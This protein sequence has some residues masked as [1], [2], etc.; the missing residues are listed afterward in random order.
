VKGRLGLFAFLLAGPAF[1][2]DAGP[3]DAKGPSLDA[4]ASITGCT[5]QIPGGKRRPDL[6]E[7]FPAKGQSGHIAVLEVSLLHGKG[8]SVLPSGF[9]LQ[10]TDAAM[11]TLEGARF[12]LPDADGG[13]GPAKE[14]ETQGEQQ[15]TR[16]KIPFVPLPDKPGRHDLSLPPVP[17]TIQRA[18]G[19]LVTLCTKSHPIVVEDPTLSTPEPKPKHNPEPRRQLEVWTV[20]K[21]VAIAAL[22]ALVVGALLAWL[23]GKWLRRP[24]P[25][26]PPPPPRPPWEVAIEE[27]F[28]IRHAGLIKQQRFAVHFDRVS[29]AI[30]KYLGER[31]GFDGL[32]CTTR[33]TLLLLNEVRP[34]IV[35]LDTIRAFLR[36]ADLVKFARLTPTEEECE[37]ALERAERIVRQTIPL[38]GQ[39]EQLAAP[40]VEAEPH[41]SE[42]SK[43]APRTPIESAASA[44][45]SESKGGTS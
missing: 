10:R 45:E 15:R 42:E 16:V 20:A 27:L 9:Q 22:I 25:A 28:D 31:F 1:A 44:S 23:L 2:N 3:A 36:Q 12:F 14:T 34:E 7:S 13:A 41:E 5:E 33:E 37:Q 8:E 18:S 40:S 6:S 24:K 30:R 17:I 4:G 21:Q 43:W 39:Q 35:V 26:P 11:R 29:S 38:P 19:E 32:E